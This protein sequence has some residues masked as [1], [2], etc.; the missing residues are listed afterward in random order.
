MP[1]THFRLPRFIYNACKPVTKN[2]K[3]LQKFK[4]TGRDLWIF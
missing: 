1:E 4:G 3:R 2:E